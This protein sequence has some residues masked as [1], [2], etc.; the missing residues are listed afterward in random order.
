M[1]YIDQLLNDA[2]FKIC[3]FEEEIEPK[4]LILGEKG[5]YIVVCSINKLA[6]IKND[7]LFKIVNFPSRMLM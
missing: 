2:A 6:F 4:K 5:L 1:Q 7:K 3:K